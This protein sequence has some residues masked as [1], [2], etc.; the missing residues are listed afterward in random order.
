MKTRLLKKLRK[1]AKRYIHL[2]PCGFEESYNQRFSHD[3]TPVKIGVSCNSCEEG[4]MK[5]YITYKD[6]VEVDGV[7]FTYGILG[8]FS[9]GWS[10]ECRL[11]EAKKILRKLRQEYILQEVERL[12]DERLFNDNE[13]EYEKFKKYI[14]SL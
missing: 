3:S 2:Y 14:Y 9:W 12:K 1:E 7:I 11:D 5:K 10:G 8:G 6:Y 4:V 13:K